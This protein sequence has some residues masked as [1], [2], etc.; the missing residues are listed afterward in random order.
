[1]NLSLTPPARFGSDRP[2]CVAILAIGGQGGGV[3][4]DWIV[5]L[6]EAQGW[7][8]QSTSVP[9]VAQRTGATIYYIEMLPLRDHRQ[10]ILSLMPTQGDVDV[11]IAA[12]LMEAGRSMIRGLVTPDRTT[13]IASTHRSYAI[14]ERTSPGDGISDPVPVVAAAGLAAKRLIAFDMETLAT[15]HASVISACLFGALAASGVLPFGREAFE[16]VI[17]SGGRGIEPSLKAFGA[18]FE[19]TREQQVGPVVAAPIKRFATLPTAAGNAQLDRLLGLIRAYPAPLQEMLFAAVRRLT[20]FQDPA[21]AQEYLDRMATLYALDCHH[22]GT[23]TGYRLSAAA[24]KYVAVAMAYD[25]VIRVAE[26]KTRIARLERV[27]QELDAKTSELVY[28]TEYMHPRLEE[29]AGTMPAGIGRWVEAHPALF[30]RFF[31]RG[32]RVRTGTIAWFLVLYSVAAMKPMRRRTLR[33]VREMAHIERWLTLA[34]A[35]VPTNY[36]LAVE[37]VGARRLVK[38]YSDTHARGQS[39]FDRVIGAV[40]VLASRE[41]GAQWLRRLRQ[42]ALI[43]ESGLA[44]D[45]ALK[46]IAT[47]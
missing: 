21:Y 20:D 46:T 25:D 47:L 19:H 1:V 15:R 3:L 45:G 6:A 14:L 27:R 10:P 43:D 38:G 5:A 13:L 32:R 40:P 35:H 39:K 36:D 42:A 4:A 29:V 17:K 2:I 18:A 16:A 33:H 22:G 41:D 26:L 7:H 9:G 11:V 31:R 23:A 8:A 28:T 24:A 37:I 30:G 34:A 44:L 12:E